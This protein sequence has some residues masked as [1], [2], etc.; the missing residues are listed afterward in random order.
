MDPGDRAAAEARTV[1][2]TE[3]R[4]ATGAWWGRG[5]GRRVG[6]EGT[7]TRV[8]DAWRGARR[9]RGKSPGSHPK[10]APQPDTGARV[11]GTAMDQPDVRGAAQPW[12]R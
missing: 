9:P 8:P 12:T 2:T 5:S 6:S 11:Q 3:D 10:A 7:A 4:P 1:Q